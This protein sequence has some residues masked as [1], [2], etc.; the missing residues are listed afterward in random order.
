MRS[1]LSLLTLSRRTFLQWEGRCLQCSADL[2]LLAGATSSIV[3]LADGG[4][5][6]ATG[7]LGLSGI[8]SV[9]IPY[10]SFFTFNHIVQNL[11]TYGFYNHH[12]VYS[13][14]RLNG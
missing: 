7:E 2:I 1:T 9:I 3:N 8:S 12:T 13:L 6:T 11:A 4:A 10:D 5:A 14:L